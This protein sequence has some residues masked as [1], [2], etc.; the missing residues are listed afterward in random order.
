MRIYCN[1]AMTSIELGYPLKRQQQITT[2]MIEK[3]AGVSGIDRLRVIHLFE[4]DYNL[5]L[6]VMWSRRAVWNI[7]NKELSNMGQAGSRPGNRA[8]DVALAQE[9]KYNY[10]K[11]TRTSLITIDNNAKSCFDSILCNV[12]ILIR[13][14]LV[15]GDKLRKLQ[16]TALKEAQFRI[17]TALGDSERTYKNT[18][19]S[20]INGTGQESCSSPAIW[21][22]VSS[23]VMDI[24]QANAIMAW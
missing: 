9:M 12:A 18:K 13:K 5:I 11:M 15:F 20:P 1:I 4:A 3:T 21:L 19:E 22:M 10:A 6:K 2:C 24:L 7:Q 14:Y 8:I 23:F 16:S 17:R